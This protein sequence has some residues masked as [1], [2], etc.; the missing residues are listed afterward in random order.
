MRRIRFCEVCRAAVIRDGDGEVYVGT[1]LVHGPLTC[2]TVRQ[3]V[4]VAPR[5]RYGGGLR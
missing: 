1:K 5:I 2:G 3:R 4:E